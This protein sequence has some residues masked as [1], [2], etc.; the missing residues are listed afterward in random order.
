MEPFGNQRALFHNKFQDR[1]ATSVVYDALNR[2]VR[3]AEVRFDGQERRID[4]LYDPYGNPEKV[5]LPF[6][7]NS[8]SYWNTYSYDDYNRMV[9]AR[10]ATGK[11][12]TYDY[13]GTKITVAENDVVTTRVYDVLGNLVSLTDPSG[14]VIYGLYA[15]GQPYSITAPENVTTT[16]EY[17]KYRRQTAISD[18]SSG[19]TN[20]EYDDAGNLS[21]VKNANGETIT[22]EYDAYNRLVLACN[23][24][25]S[26]SYDYNDKNEL[27]GITSSDGMVKLYSHDSF[28]R[29]TKC[30]EFGEDEKWLLKEYAYADGN[31]SSVTYTSPSGKL[32]T[33]NRIYENGR[34]TET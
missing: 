15:D 24:E 19:T 1:P 11:K 17:D 20:Y 7:G 3:N 32:A 2:E 33:E 21:Q 13:E 26:T 28:G 10:E 18:P 8:A 4:K 25:F 14:T 5:S 16:F 6:F 27:T 29:L 30:V 9:S 31:I 23:Q 22:H 34:L 12:T